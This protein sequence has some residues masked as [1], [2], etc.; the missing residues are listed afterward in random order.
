MTRQMLPAYYT[1]YVCVGNEII[2]IVMIGHPSKELGM[3]L[4]KK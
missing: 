4:Q 2:F 3:L 1:E